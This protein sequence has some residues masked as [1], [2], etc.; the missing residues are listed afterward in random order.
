[1]FEAMSAVE[2]GDPKL[3]AGLTM[4]Y[5][6]PA[7]RWLP[8][9]LAVHLGTAVTLLMMAPCPARPFATGAC[10]VA[11]QAQESVAQASKRGGCAAVAVVGGGAGGDGPPGSARGDLACGPL[12]RA[13]CVYLP[14]PAAPAAVRAHPCP[15]LHRPGTMTTAYSPHTRI[16]IL[17][18]PCFT[19]SGA[20]ACMQLVQG[21]GKSTCP[22]HP[23][24][25]AT[26]CHAGYFL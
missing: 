23:Q 4:D 13:D 5:S 10:A 11:Q 6:V 12:A 1:M 2:I 25:C 14:L 17:L 22:L 3:D 21:W 15:R 24:G 7:D 26:A 18:C 19:L 20:G 8:A 9:A 16:H